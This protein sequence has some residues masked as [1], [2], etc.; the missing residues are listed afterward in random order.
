VAVPALKNLSRSNKTLTDCQCHHPIIIR[1]MGRHALRKYALY[2]R[3]RMEFF[4]GVYVVLLCSMCV[5]EFVNMVIV[6]NSNGDIRVTTAL[7]LELY[8]AVVLIVGGLLIIRTGMRANRQTKLHK[9]WNTTAHGLR[10][11]WWTKRR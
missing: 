5:Y 11:T 9:R 7:V 10:V 4:L 3:R 6:V 2:F 1:N 8:M